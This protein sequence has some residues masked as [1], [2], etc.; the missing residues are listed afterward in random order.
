MESFIDMATHEFTRTRTLA[1][2]ALEPLSDVQ[3]TTVIGDDANSVAILVKHMAGNL[4][5]RWTDFL[6]TDGEKPDRARDGEFVLSDVDSRGALMV[7][8]AAGWGA[9]FEALA[10]LTDDDLSRT[11]TIRG[12]AFT[13]QQA[14]LRQQTHYAYH[15]GQIV[16]IARQLLGASWKTLSVPRGASEAFNEAPTSYLDRT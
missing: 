4:R 16:L 9:L 12:E 15:V 13:V 10:P 7:A 8:W 6:T 5:S 3:F 1:E 14:I 11:V 2:R